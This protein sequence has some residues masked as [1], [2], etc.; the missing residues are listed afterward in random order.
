MR[1]LRWLC[2]F[3]CFHQNDFLLHV[4]FEFNLFL[5]WTQWDLPS[6]PGKASHCSYDLWFDCST[7]FLTPF[8]IWSLLL[9]DFIWSDENYWPWDWYCWNWIYEIKLEWNLTSVVLSSMNSRSFSW[10]VVQRI[11]QSN[12]SISHTS[13]NQSISHTNAREE[14]LSRQSSDLWVCDWMPYS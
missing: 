7:M 9:G 2:V 10:T 13:A 14:F 11:S 8:W 12:Q 3:F 1:W 4:K 6:Y 5:L